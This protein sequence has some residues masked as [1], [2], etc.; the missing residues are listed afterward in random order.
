MDAGKVG[1]MEKRKNVWTEK[2][3]KQQLKKKHGAG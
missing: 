3:Q 2:C 1:A